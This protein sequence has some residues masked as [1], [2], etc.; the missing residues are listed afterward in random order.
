MTAVG[1][2]SWVMVTQRTPIG[3]R[4]EGGEWREKKEGEQLDV[5]RSRRLFLVRG[6]VRMVDEVA[7]APDGPDVRPLGEA[8]T[9]GS[10]GRAV[11]VIE[12]VYSVSFQSKI[13]A[14]CGVGRQ[15][16][17]FFSEF[18]ENPRKI[19]AFDVAAWCSHNDEIGPRRAILFASKLCKK[20]SE[21]C[22][23][24]I[25]DFDQVPDE[26]ITNLEKSLA[27]GCKSWKKPEKS[28]I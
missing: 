27:R 3:C 5:E 16:R 19:K 26:I 18:V 11:S 2:S 7:A 20:P 10:V 24:T 9:F 13:N 22:L 6:V 8:M 17:L 14:L 4:R 23:K 1:K 25:L 28:K 21:I 12:A 15:N